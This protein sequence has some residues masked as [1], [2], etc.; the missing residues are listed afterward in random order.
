MHKK[1]FTFRE[2][3]LLL[4]EYNNNNDYLQF[5]NEKSGGLLCFLYSII[6]S[7]GFSR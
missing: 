6:L 1:T 3:L 5:M 4:R 2:S 7:K